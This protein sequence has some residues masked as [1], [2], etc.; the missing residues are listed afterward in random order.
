MDAILRCQP[1][2]AVILDLGCGS[3]SLLGEHSGSLVVHGD[4]SL[5]SG[6]RDF[7]QLDAA[8]L[9][10]KSGS[11]DL[12]ISNHS[13]EHFSKWEA[14]ICEMGRAVKATGA[15][16]VAVPDSS[17]L[18][19][20]LYRWLAR[21]GGHLNRFTSA[22][23]LAVEIESRTDLRH[24]ATR[25]LCSSFSF[26]HSQN[27]SR[28]R[29]RKMVLFAYGAE[30]LLRWASYVLRLLDRFS[31]TRLSVYGW[32]LY[33]GSVGDVVDTRTRTNVCIRCGAG[34][35]SAWLTTAGRV[36]SGLLVRRYSCPQCGTRNLFTSDLDYPHLR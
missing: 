33:F 32:A 34:H 23:E 20:R 16:Y 31:G 12:I 3:G 35:P 14:A 1:S 36:R 30:P 21:G 29:P 2:D 17:T 27:Q 8:A 26:L 10:F 24:V 19:D 25:V 6:L 7:V 15:L 5:F 11:Y 28:T 9:P 18:T 4:L 22:P 13:L